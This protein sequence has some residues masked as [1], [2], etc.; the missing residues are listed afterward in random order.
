V[1]PLRGARFQQLNSPGD[2]NG[3]RQRKQQVNVIRYA[4]GRDR[5][6]RVLSRDPAQVSMQSIPHLFIVGCRPLVLNT[7]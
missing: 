4:S 2:G 1:D 5:H 3:T 6:H 7:R